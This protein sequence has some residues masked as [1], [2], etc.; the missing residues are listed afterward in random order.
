MVLVAET[1]VNNTIIRYINNTV[2]VTKNV[3]VEHTVVKEIAKD[4]VKLDAGK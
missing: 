1:S 4:V 2:T 3:T